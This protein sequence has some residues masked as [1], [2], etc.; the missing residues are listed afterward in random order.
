MVQ[1]TKKRFRKAIWEYE[2]PLLQDE[3]RLEFP[4]DASIRYVDTQH[5]VPM[6]WVE[7]DLDKAADE[8]SYETVRFRIAGTRH[9]FENIEV[10]PV[11]IDA[12]IDYFCDP[13][14]HSYI[15]TFLMMGGDLVFHLFQMYVDDVP[16]DVEIVDGPS[17][18]DSD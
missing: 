12:G 18:Q 7:V 15:G 17:G 11:E 1:V 13:K 10:R 6:M 3:F 2:I 14:Y 9:E 4:Q 5:G 8:A 16:D